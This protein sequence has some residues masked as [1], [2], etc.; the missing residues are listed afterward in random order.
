MNVKILKGVLNRN[1]NEN[2]VNLLFIFS[3]N[4][5]NNWYVVFIFF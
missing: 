5:S 3:Y 1:E 4:F 2:I